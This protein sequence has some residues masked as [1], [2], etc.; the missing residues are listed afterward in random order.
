MKKNKNLN[1]KP[2]EVMQKLE[3]SQVNR[4]NKV[5]KKNNQKNLIENKEV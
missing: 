3:E 5:K 2:S 1:Q 4:E